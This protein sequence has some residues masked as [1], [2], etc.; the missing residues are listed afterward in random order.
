ME[1]VRSLYQITAAR[2]IWNLTDEKTTLDRL[3]SQGTINSNTVIYLS[4]ICGME[5]THEETEKYWKELNTPYNVNIAYDGLSI[6]KETDMFTD[7]QKIR[8]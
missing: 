1:N 2:Y 4:H 6:D 5:K 3:F 8:L 7:K